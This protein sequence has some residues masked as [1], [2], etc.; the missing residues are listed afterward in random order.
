MS[1]MERLQKEKNIEN[2]DNSVQKN[3]K[4]TV[5]EK[6]DP[7]KELK[8]KIYEKVIQNIKK[9]NFKEIIESEKTD[10]LKE[11]ITNVIESVLDGENTYI[12]KSDRIQI[13][14]EIINESIGFGPITPLL[15]DPSIS[16]IMVNGPKKVYVEKKGKL[17]LSDVTF[18]NDEHVMH[19]IEKIVA[20]IGRRIDESSPM[21]D[22]RLPNGSR[23]NIIIPP[24]ALNGP[25]ITIRKFSE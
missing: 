12:A 1:L 21:V 24:L 10:E 2:A 19:V 4:A 22:A 16:E 7:F 8:S 5:V 9:E 13:I 17:V 25:T 20:P 18:D 6:I 15:Y 14:N 23:V 3:K 11:E